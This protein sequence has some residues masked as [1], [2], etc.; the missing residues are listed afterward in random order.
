MKDWRDNFYWVGPFHED[1]AAVR[2]DDKY[3]Y[4]NKK[5]KETKEE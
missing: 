3:F 1:R 4:V 2:I 5:G